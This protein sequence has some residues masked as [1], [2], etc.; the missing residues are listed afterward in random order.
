MGISVLPGYSF[1]GININI[2]LY[3]FMLPLNVSVLK[4]GGG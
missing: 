3:F 4:F 2:V 1:A